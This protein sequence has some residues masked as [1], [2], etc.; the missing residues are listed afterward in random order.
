MD[1]KDMIENIIQNKD[2]ISSINYKVN[3]KVLGGIWTLLVINAV[4]QL[5]LKVFLQDDED[6]TMFLMITVE[7]GLLCILPILV[8]NRSSW[9]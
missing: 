5:L 4:I 3:I 9:T 1:M 8:T 7:L 6:W 2:N